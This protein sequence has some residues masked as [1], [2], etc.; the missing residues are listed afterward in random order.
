MKEPNF[1]TEPNL[2]FLQLMN[3]YSANYGFSE[4]KKW[5]LDWLTK[6][7]PD[8]AIRLS[9]FSETKFSNRGFVCRILANGYPLSEDIPEK[10]TSYFK[11]MHQDIPSE[12]VKPKQ[13]KK[14]TLNSIVYQI[15]ELIDCVISAKDIPEI[16]IPV[17][18]KQLQGARKWIEAEM[19][20]AQE[21]LRQQELIIEKLADVYTRCGGI[22]E[23][24]TKKRETAKN[25]APSK[26]TLSQLK[27]LRYHKDEY[28]G[29]KGISPTKIFGAKKLLTFNTDTRIAT[30][31]VATDKT[32]LF[33][34]GSTIKGYD[35]DKSYSIRIRKPELFLSAS[36]PF[37]ALNEQKTTKA[38]A[39][40]LTSE[41][42]L[43]LS[44]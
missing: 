20:E 4:S 24:T 12:Q 23:A 29:V 21:R 31:Y 43:L 30:L 28:N 27:S 5:A 7:N 44:V 37:D 13:A 19:I 8:E 22:V 11:N 25:A 33:V 41:N 32:G 9:G 18:A 42:T 36:N 1:K 10:L 2:T 34:K 3:F 17:D 40:G 6:N 26:P 14:I 38:V 15:D 39:R 16:D 35:A